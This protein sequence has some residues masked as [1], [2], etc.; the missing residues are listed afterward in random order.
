MVLPKV[1]AL[2][3]VSRKTHINTRSPNT[4]ELEVEN[5]SV[6]VG[7]VDVDVILSLELVSPTSF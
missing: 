7:V 5:T 4:Q 2:A 3:Q 6:Q 1:G